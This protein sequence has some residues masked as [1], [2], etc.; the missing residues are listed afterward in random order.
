MEKLQKLIQEEYGNGNIVLFTCE[1]IV[2]CN[3]E[4]FISQH[5]AGIL[6]DLN[7]LECVN[8]SLAEKDDLRWIND[9]A[10]AHVIIRLK[11]KLNK[12]EQKYASNKS[13]QE[14]P[15]SSHAG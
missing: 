15:P 13:K 7:H 8:L 3:M 14:I 2:T 4:E 10:V 11:E 1:G 5:T 6:Y 9:I 12:Y